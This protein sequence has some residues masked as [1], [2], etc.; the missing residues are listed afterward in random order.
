MPRAA[1]AIIAIACSA[2]Y[3]SADTGVLPSNVVTKGRRNRA[4]SRRSSSK[5]EDTELRYIESPDKQDETNLASLAAWNEDI[6]DIEAISQVCT[7]LDTVLPDRVRCKTPPAGAA[8]D[9]STLP[10]DIFLRAVQYTG[11]KG[12]T[13]SRSAKHSCDD[14]LQLPTFPLRLQVKQHY[15]FGPQ[16][17][18]TTTYS[19]DVVTPS[20]SGMVQMMTDCGE[21]N[22]GIVHKSAKSGGQVLRLCH[23]LQAL[24]TQLGTNY[25]EDGRTQVEILASD[26]TGRTVLDHAYKRQIFC[27]KA[28]DLVELL[29]AKDSLAATSHDEGIDA[30]SII[31]RSRQLSRRSKA[32]RP[33]R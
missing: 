29:T 6:T 4:L 2:S 30:T 12:R 3:L 26:A 15:Y 21:E 31:P 9:L 13:L 33:Q 17:P 1:T 20:S 11:I 8:V 18:L 22:N 19:L 23:E 16:E 32:S 5:R 28:D 10:D 24:Q 14:V 25:K 7:I 27:G